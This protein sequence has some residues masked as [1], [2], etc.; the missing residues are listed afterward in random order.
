MGVLR[1]A[2]HRGPAG[3]RVPP[4]LG[5]FHH[6]RIPCLCA[7][8]GGLASRY[9][10]VARG[11]S[12]VC[13]TVSACFT[14]TLIRNQVLPQILGSL[15]EVIRSCCHHHHQRSSRG[16]LEWSARFHALNRPSR[17]LPEGLPRGRLRV[18]L[19]RVSDPPGLGRRQG[20]Q[21]AAR[22]TI[23]E[24]RYN[25][26]HPRPRRARCTIVHTRISILKRYLSPESPDH[27]RDA[28]NKVCRCNKSSLVSIDSVAFITYFY[29]LMSHQL[30]K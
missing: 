24:K 5:R 7:G 16:R 3:G 11:E 6:R 12:D 19:G 13:V 9:C 26:S 22:G 20:A 14:R 27:T 8:F 23:R 15:P 21:R 1:S 25:L 10:G 2:A 4:V 29:L 30:H 28:L 18:A 17:T